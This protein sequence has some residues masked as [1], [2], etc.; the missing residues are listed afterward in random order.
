MM[1]KMM[2][3]TYCTKEEHHAAEWKATGITKVTW[4]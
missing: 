1:M 2:E 3:N 4:K